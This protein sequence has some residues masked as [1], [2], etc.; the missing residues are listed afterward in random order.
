[1]MLMSSFVR[2][3]YEVRWKAL[4]LIVLI[5]LSSSVLADAIRQIELQYRD[6][7]ST[8]ALLDELFEDDVTIVVDSN[9]LLIRGATADVQAIAVMVER[10]DRPPTR[11]RVSLYR[12]VDPYRGDPNADSR[13]IST[14]HRNRDNIF[15]QWE[16]DNGTAFLMQDVHRIVEQTQQVV[17]STDGVDKSTLLEANTTQTSREITEHNIRLTLTDDQQSVRV[18]V[19]TQLPNRADVGE[20]DEL[21]RSQVESRRLLP[22]RE[23]KRLFYRQNQANTFTPEKVKKAT[24]ELNFDDEQA[25]WIYVEPLGD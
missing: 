12:G 7:E 5:N 21:I 15:D 11:L 10:L 18:V 22:T 25:L 4:V 17:L 13:K 3:L 1:M 20:G 24:T 19:L 16:M 9:Y 8:K 23:W 2:Y 6:A 14:T